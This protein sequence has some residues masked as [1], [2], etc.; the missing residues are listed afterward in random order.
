[1]YMYI[2]ENH[3]ILVGGMGCILVGEKSK[4]VQSPNRLQSNMTVLCMQVVHVGDLFFRD[5]QI[6]I[7]YMNYRRIPIAPL[8]MLTKHIYEL[9][10][11]FITFSTLNI[12][13]WLT[14]E[15]EIYVIKNK[16]FKYR[17]YTIKFFDV[18]P[19][20]SSN[21]LDNCVSWDAMKIQWK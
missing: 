11:L 20:Q 2:R 10:I 5:A 13:Q 1:M 14:H 18:S 17:I 9:W 8:L 6:F 21:I 12:D 16:F 7:F 15:N 19:I 4:Y 3:G